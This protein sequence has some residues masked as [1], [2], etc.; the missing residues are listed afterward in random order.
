MIWPYLLGAILLIVV[1]CAVDFTLMARRID[2]LNR[3]VVKSRLALAHALNARAR[4][5]HEFADLGVLDVASSILLI[6]AAEAC[7]SASM[8]PLVDDGLDTIELSSQSHSLVEASPAQITTPRKEGV[9]RRS[10]ESTLSRTLRLTVDELTEEEL[11]TAVE[12]CEEGEEICSLYEKLERARLDVRMTRSFHNSHVSRI[13]DVRRGIIVRI[14]FIAG[15]APLPQTVDID[16][17]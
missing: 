11:S 7:Q 2:R 5:A 16:D 9:D 6:D 15:R 1:V 12:S 10:L 4:Y 14:F 17:E 8:L 3:T 13:H